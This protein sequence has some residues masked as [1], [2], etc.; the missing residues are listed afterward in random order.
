MLLRKQENLL[1]LEHGVYFQ[2]IKCFNFH[3]SHQVPILTNT[4]LMV[5]R[6]L[7]KYIHLMQMLEPISNDVFI[8][9]T[10]LLDFYVLTV[11]N[12]FTR[13]LVSIYLFHVKPSQEKRAHL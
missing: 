8:S 2:I 11:F 4:S 9:M 6:L 10:Q 3:S 5:L 1:D 12:H 7:G 13:D